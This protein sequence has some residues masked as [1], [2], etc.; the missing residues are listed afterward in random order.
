MKGIQIYSN[1]TENNIKEIYQQMKEWEIHFVDSHVLEPDCGFFPSILLNA[2]YL[3]K[4]FQL[5]P[6]NFSDIM[7]ELQLNPTTFNGKEK[8][9]GEVN[10][11]DNQY[12]NISTDINSYNNLLDNVKFENIIDFCGAVIELYPNV[13]NDYG[14]HAIFLLKSINNDFFIIDDQNDLTN[15]I[16]YYKVRHERISRMVIR[17]INGETISQINKIIP[18]KFNAKATKY[19]LTFSGNKFTGGNDKFNWITIF[20]FIFIFIIII[21]ILILSDSIPLQSYLNYFHS[22]LVG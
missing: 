20:I 2:I 6:N 22:L 18:F 13:K 19:E 8:Y 5:F 11:E 12:F 17:D 15:I 4:I 9:V 1:I 16:D 14:A 21:S 7:K 3:P 10:L